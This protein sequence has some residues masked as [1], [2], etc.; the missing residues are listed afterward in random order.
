MTAGTTAFRAALAAAF[1]LS[2]T[3]LPVTQASARTLTSIKAGERCSWPYAPAGV[4]VGHFLG[5]EESKFVS[6]DSIRQFTT[7][8]CF[9]S[10]KDCDNWLYTMQSAYPIAGSQGRCRYKG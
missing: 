2:V 1:A 9:R 5:Y 4:Y 6:D 8:R 7:Q 10:A 3:A